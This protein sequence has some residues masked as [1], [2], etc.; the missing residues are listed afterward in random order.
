M[1]FTTWYSEVNTKITTIF[2][3]KTITNN[4]NCIDYLYL[5]NSCYYDYTMNCDE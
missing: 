5:L 2:V 4:K 3:N 1:R